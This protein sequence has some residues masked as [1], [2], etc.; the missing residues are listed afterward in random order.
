LGKPAEQ[1]DGTEDVEQ[2]EALEQHHINA[3]HLAMVIRD[4]VYED[5]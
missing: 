3:P 5:Q 1:L 4:R 2:L